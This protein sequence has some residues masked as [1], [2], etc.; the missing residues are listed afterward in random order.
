MMSIEPRAA[1]AAALPIRGRLPPLDGASAW[2][3]SAPLTTEA[4][5]GKV[6]LVDF[7]TYSCI[8]CIRTLPYVEAWYEKYRDQGLVVIGVHTP[9]FSFEKRVENVR[10]AVAK[11]GISYPVA[12]DNDYS[13]WRAFSNRYWPAHYFVDTAGNIRHMHFGE[14]DYD[15]SERVIRQL[16]AEAGRSSVH[17]ATV[18]PSISAETVDAR[19]TGVALA[20]SG[21]DVLSPE[22]YV[23]YGRASNFA[24]LGGQRHD[25]AHAYSIPTRLALN[26]WALEGIWNVREEFAALD[27]NTGRIAFHFQ[28]RDLHLVLSPGPNG[29]PVRFRVRIDGAPPGDEHGTDVDATGEGTVSEQRLYQLIRQHGHV[30][31][32]VFEIE[33]LDGGVEAYAFTFG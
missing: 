6:V 8:N 29:R 23:G 10:R 27:G 31:D 9:E 7:W 1:A 24:S 14:G 21:L 4:L 3:N 28:A 12:V 11:F 22:T 16:L 33:F 19:G 18:Q 13:L 32:R 5:R 26:D 25:A 30:R 2:L 15:V 20:S 17:A